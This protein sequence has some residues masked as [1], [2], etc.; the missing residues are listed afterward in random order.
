VADC[1]KQDNKERATPMSIIID[2]KP[3]L[4][5]ELSRQAAARG[6]DIGS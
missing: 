5:A 4:Q 6:V 3:E 1:R 2:V